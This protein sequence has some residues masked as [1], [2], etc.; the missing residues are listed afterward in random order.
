MASAQE[1]RQGQPRTRNYFAPYFTRGH[2]L[3]LKHYEPCLAKV[4]RG[5]LIRLKV[6]QK[7]HVPDYG[8][9][10]PKNKAGKLV[11]FRV[12]M[13]FDDMDAYT[14]KSVHAWLY[15]FLRT[16]LYHYWF[17]ILMTLPY[18]IYQYV[19]GWWAM[20]VIY[21]LCTLDASGLTAHHHALPILWLV[22][23][24]G[25]MFNGFFGWKQE[26]VVFRVDT[27]A[28]EL[29]MCETICGEQEKTSYEAISSAPIS[30]RCLND[31]R[32]TGKKMPSMQKMAYAH[33]IQLVTAAWVMGVAEL[34]DPEAALA[35]RSADE[36]PILEDSD[37]DDDI[38]GKSCKAA[39]DVQLKDFKPMR[40]P[41]LLCRT[42]T[43][44]P[45]ELRPSVVVKERTQ[46]QL[47]EDRQKGK[48]VR[49]EG[50]DEKKIDYSGVVFTPEIIKIIAG[51]T[52]NKENE[53]S[54]VNRHFI[55]LEHPLKPGTFMLP[56]TPEA[57]RRLNVASDVIAAHMRESAYLWLHKICE[58]APPTKWS[59]TMK[60]EMPERAE[61]ARA[62][63]GSISA[64]IQRK[65]SGFVKSS[66]LQLPLNKNAR[67]IG[68]LGPVANMEDAMSIAPIEN[69]LKIAYPKLITK[70]MTLAECDE[71][72]TQDLL[73]CRREGRI[74][75]SDDLSAMDSS[76][77]KMDRVNLRK[78]ANAV[79]EPVRTA[80]TTQLRNYD[81]VLDAEEHGKKLKMQLNYI[82]VLIDADDSI[83][84]SGERMTSLFNRL[85]ILML[86]SAEDIK[87]LGEE[88]GTAAIRETLDGIRQTTRGDGDD[89]LQQLIKGRYKTQEERI[90]AYAEYFKKLDP[91][92]AF[93]ETTDAEV[94]SR[95]H[96][97]CG[98][99][100]GYVHIGKLERNLGRL[101]AFKIQRSNIPEDQKDTELSQAELA[102][103]CTDVWQRVIS[104]KQT[105]VV[106]HF[107]RATFDYAFSKLKDKSR[108]TV[109]DEDMKR[110]GREDGD[111]SLRDC[112]TQIYEVIS[113]AR[114][115]SYAMVKVSHFKTFSQLSP[116]EVRQEMKA[117]EEADYAWSRMEFDD[118]HILYPQSLIED[119]PIAKVVCRHLGL[120][121]SCIDMGTELPT[122]VEKTEKRAGSLIL[123]ASALDESIS[124]KL[125]DVTGPSRT[126]GTKSGSSNSKSNPELFSIS[127][128]DE[129][130]TQSQKSAGDSVNV[131]IDL[132]P[133]DSGVGIHGA[134][135]GPANSSSVDS[136]CLEVNSSNPFRMENTIAKGTSKPNSPGVQGGLRSV[137]ISATTTSSV[138][139][140][141]AAPAKQSEEWL[142]SA[143]LGSACSSEV[144]NAV[145]LEPTV[146]GAPGLQL[147]FEAAHIE[148]GQSQTH[149]KGIVEPCESVGGRP[150]PARLLIADLLGAT[151]I[152]RESPPQ[153]PPIDWSTCP[154][155]GCKCES[156][157]K[158]YSP[159]P[160]AGRASPASVG[161]SPPASTKGQG[162]GKGK[163]GGKTS[164][165]RRGKRGAG[166]THP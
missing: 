61:Q 114:T 73:R 113:E 99:M 134:A 107:A 22:T 71:A 162:K 127:S 50:D 27:Q 21:H 16:T 20:K 152:L 42:C 70:A 160:S 132:L 28:A 38:P 33:V 48:K 158:L 139:G 145:F 144:P 97:W 94:L 147:P 82:T 1:T 36:M 110:L 126:G 15:R 130:N 19:T 9:P 85:M 166:G 7:M 17:G 29:I 52:S 137:E 140:E 120:I 39:E 34:H 79:L 40:W 103:I 25:W 54:G 62:R 96:I 60:D 116:E 12:A 18:L 57:Q 124:G 23:S 155:P 156:C 41:L 125:A 159:P 68:N 44:I 83:L 75:E 93:D 80:L 78:I 141:W 37:T 136:S 112:Q 45:K 13:D 105:L 89:N 76:I 104:L 6:L 109:Y 43:T 106:R 84:F 118:K 11:D 58:F 67:L 26:Y 100:I 135:C 95:F 5:W 49:I 108:G 148:A 24:L 122:R 131:T 87:F 88:A 98:E 151:E 86:E 91:C 157:W 30:S 47:K 164:G 55:Q 32:E 3:K 123:L 165:N 119:F 143:S 90:E 66:E 117:W 133:V 59:A 149:C 69:L 102:M 81:H 64:W 115:S 128:D 53:L 4:W 142:G 46:E 121:Q 72:I 161:S 31:S 163:S 56:P 146:R 51:L 63:D 92:S 10:I 153:H 2:E 111:R 150:Q 154:G 138:T 65:L 8:Y 74:P 77:R 35:G 129:D 101:I 14:G